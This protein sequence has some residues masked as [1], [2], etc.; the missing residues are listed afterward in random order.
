MFHADF[1]FIRDL[2]DIEGKTIN[3]NTL[4]K[5]DL[6]AREYLLYR[7]LRH[8]IKRS[9]GTETQMANTNKIYST[10]LKIKQIYEIINNQHHKEHSSA[11][12]KYIRIV[13]LNNRLRNFNSK[14]Y[15]DI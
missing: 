6:E 5:M 1:W 11:K 15:I 2:F 3:I 12:L 9:C 14:F 10:D 4:Y 8:L 13:L 7:G